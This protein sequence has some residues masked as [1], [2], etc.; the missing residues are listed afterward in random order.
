MVREINIFLKWLAEEISEGV[1]VLRKMVTDKSVSLLW[2]GERKKKHIR[3]GCE[4]DWTV[5]RQKYIGAFVPSYGS[6]KSIKR[7]TKSRKS[8]K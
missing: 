2:G 8:R 3:S 6:H 7:P 5:G 4:T 1:R